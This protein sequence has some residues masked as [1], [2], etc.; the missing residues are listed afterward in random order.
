MSL[1]TTIRAG[2]SARLRE[3]ADFA[4]AAFDLP[5]PGEIVL[6]SGTAAGK[7]DVLFSDQRTLGP[8]ANEDLDLSGALTN[9]AGGSAVFAKVKAI[10][11]KAAGGDANDVAVKPAAINGFLGPFADVSDKLVIPPG[12]M[13]LLAAPVDGWAVTAGSGD[14]LNIANSGAGTSVTYDIVI[15]GTSA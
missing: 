7:A 5:F 14:L 8:S 6:K 15:V 10:Y 12:G 13:A 4:E 9:A 11:V 3:S 1:V 2:I